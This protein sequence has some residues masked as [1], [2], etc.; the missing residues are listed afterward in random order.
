L[1]GKSTALLLSSYEQEQVCF[2]K[3]SADVSYLRPF[4]LQVNAA[5]VAVEACEF[6]F[7]EGRAGFIP[8]AANPLL[9]YVHILGTGEQLELIGVER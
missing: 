7:P 3:A 8:C 2:L 5:E 1:S 6:K 9:L 4:R